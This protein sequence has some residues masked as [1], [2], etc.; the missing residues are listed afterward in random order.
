MCSIFTWHVIDTASYRMKMGKQMIFWLVALALIAAAVYYFFMPA[1]PYL[2]GFAPSTSVPIDQ[3]KSAIT[4]LYF[5]T[6]SATLS[7]DTLN[8]ALV[9]LSAV[10]PAS[11][12]EMSKTCFDAL[13][14]KY[15]L[16]KSAI[17]T[18]A[19]VNTEAAKQIISVLNRQ[20][21]S[22]YGTLDPADVEFA[23]RNDSDL[24]GTC[25]I[26]SG[27]GTITKDCY[28]KLISK[29]TSIS[30][31]PSA[32]NSMEESNDDIKDRR[33]EVFLAMAETAGH[34]DVDE[35]DVR[36]SYDDMTKS[37]GKKSQSKDRACYED[38]AKDLKITLFTPASPAYDDIKGDKSTSN[39]A[40]KLPETIADEKKSYDSKCTVEFGKEAATPQIKAATPKTPDS[41]CDTTGTISKTTKTPAVEQGCEFAQKFPKVNVI[42]LRDYVH[43]DEVPCWSCK[44]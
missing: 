22:S 35:D 1:G 15:S 19:N 13:V 32:P 20:L 41:T 38:I 3:G 14:S 16:N 36:K 5:L 34:D 21:G 23:M 8:A 9:E 24:M 18:P 25:T 37:C 10:C 28:N 29:F 33:V 6:K 39:A 11:A 44:L 40:S 27:T 7:S 2:E 17:S 42:N 43:K 12:T 4:N 26:N 31:P 30:T